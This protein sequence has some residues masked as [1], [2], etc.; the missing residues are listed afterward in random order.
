MRSGGYQIVKIDSVEN[1]GIEDAKWAVILCGGRGSRMGNLASD[2]PKPLLPVHGKPIL[3]Y[4]FWT[5]YKHGFRNFVLPLGYKGEMVDE[6]MW[7]LARDSGCQILSRDTGNDTP[8]AQRIDQISDMIPDNMDFLLLNSD[9]IFDFD[10]EGMYQTH[11]DT[12]SL[13]TLSSVEVVSSWGL[14]LMKGEKLTGFDRQRKVRQLISDNT[15]G[16]HGLVNSGLAYINKAALA[17]VDLNGCEDFETSL[18]Q[19]IIGMKRATHFQL[20]GLWFPIDTPKDLQ[21]IN[22]TI[23]DRHASGHAVKTVRDSLDKMGNSTK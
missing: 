6:Y 18:Y 3:W 20:R 13:V 9:T 8:I 21:V 12:N 16:T 14:I 19:R 22:L 5:L 4:T 23:E 10:I 1:R 2:M 7:G 15:S 11:K 17:H